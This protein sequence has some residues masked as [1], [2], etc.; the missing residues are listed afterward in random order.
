M[1]EELSRWSGRDRDLRS[2]TAAIS[3]SASSITQ[4]K[5]KVIEDH[6]RHVIAKKQSV[7]VRGVLLFR[8]SGSLAN[9]MIRSA[10]RRDEFMNRRDLL[11]FSVCTN[12]GTV[13]GGLP[14]TDAVTELG[15]K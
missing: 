14:A 12:I 5:P 6:M 11:I 2:H 8:T 15:S 7:M 4:S 9:T 3:A 10:I 1:F 13:V